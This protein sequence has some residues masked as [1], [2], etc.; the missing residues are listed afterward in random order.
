MRKVWPRDEG[1]GGKRVED[2][3]ADCRYYTEVHDSGSEQGS[4]EGREE[5][6][7]IR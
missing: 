3:P 1:K 5:T 6:G 7:L 4:E 2:G